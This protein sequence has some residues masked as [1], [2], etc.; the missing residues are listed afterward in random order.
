MG[1]AKQQLYAVAWKYKKL[2]TSQ[3]IADV[4][5][6]C[7]QIRVLA[8]GKLLKMLAAFG[9]LFA[10]HSL[11]CVHLTVA[12]SAWSLVGPLLAQTSNKD[13]MNTSAQ[14]SVESP[15][16][17]TQGQVEAANEGKE[18]QTQYAAALDGTELISLDSSSPL[19]L[20]LGATVLVDGTATRNAALFSI[21]WT[22]SAGHVF[23]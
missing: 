18:Q 11:R 13:R 1:V 21:A 20:L 2:H 12:L 5:N 10:A 14:S 6:T 4:P 15:V 22:P 17:T 7:R 16:S 8:D 23:Q 3:K 19:H 9:H